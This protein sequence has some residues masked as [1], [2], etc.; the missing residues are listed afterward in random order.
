MFYDHVGIKMNIILAGLKIKTFSTTLKSFLRILRD[1]Q[2]F[3]WAL[4]STAGLGT[5]PADRMAPGPASRA[6]E[7]RRTLPAPHLVVRT[8]FLRWRASP[9]VLET[10]FFAQQTCDRARDRCRPWG[11]GLQGFAV[12]APIFS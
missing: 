12:T 6:V 4:K 9:P 7:R 11:P 1:S 3:S 2:T 5:V 10:R 8:S